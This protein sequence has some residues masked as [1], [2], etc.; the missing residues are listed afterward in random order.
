[1]KSAPPWALALWAVAI[2]PTSAVDAATC[3]PPDS[4][5]FWPGRT[6]HT[7]VCP[8]RPESALVSFQGSVKR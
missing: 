5:G 1:M 6:R 7:T 3:R 8:L 4:T 2:M